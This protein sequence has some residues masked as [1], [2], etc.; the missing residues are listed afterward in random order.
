M[1]PHFAADERPSLFEVPCAPEDLT[2]KTELDHDLSVYA[3]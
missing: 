3:T 2:A 1:A